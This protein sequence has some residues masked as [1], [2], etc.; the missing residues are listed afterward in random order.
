MRADEVDMSLKF[1]VF[2]PDVP[3]F[4]GT[5]W[6]VECSSDSIKI[7][8]ELWYSKITPQYCFIADN[9]PDDVTIIF[10]GQPD[11]FFNLLFILLKIFIEPGTQGNVNS[12]FSSK[13]WNLGLDTFNRISS[14]G[15]GGVGKYFQ[16]C[17]DLLFAGKIVNRWIIFGLHGG[18]RKPLNTA[19][20]GWLNLGSV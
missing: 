2:K 1:L 18:K 14:Y 10:S 5:D 16:I 6:Y 13:S 7:V 4:G 9:N 12:I 20:P 15:V 19:G 11:D 3:W 17:L 8:R